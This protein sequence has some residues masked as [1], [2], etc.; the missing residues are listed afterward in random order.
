MEGYE[1]KRIE[2]VIKAVD[3]FVTA[4]GCK[5]V[6]RLEHMQAMKDTA[7]VCNI[8]HFD[9]EIQVKELNKYQGIKK[10]QI[11]PQV[12]LY[13]FPDGHR[14]ILLAEGRLVNLGCATGHPSFVMSNSFSNQVLAQIELF[15]KKYAVGVHFLPK[16]LDEKVAALHLQQLG[17]KLTKLSTEQAN[18]LGIKKNG[19]FKAD[20]YRY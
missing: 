8:G 11:K 16:E 3:I 6:I 2:D 5:D 9:I 1:V 12:D 19:P 4:T 18:Y 10:Q 15:T 17:V 7:I 20:Y 14:I 13:T